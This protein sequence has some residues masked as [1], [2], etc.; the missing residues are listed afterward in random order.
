MQAALLAVVRPDNT[1]HGYNLTYAFPALVFIIVAGALYLIFRGSHQVPGH[2][3]L[4]SSRW[5]R[6]GAAGAASTAAAPPAAG[7]SAPGAEAPEPA[8]GGPE[9]AEGG[10]ESSEGG[11]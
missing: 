11:A 1:P 6:A 5:A 9:H 7:V 8:A 2:V 4:A 3:G 10:G